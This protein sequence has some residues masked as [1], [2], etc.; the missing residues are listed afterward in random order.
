MPLR[1]V[2]R[3]LLY[4][5][6]FIH[7]DKIPSELSL[8]QADQ[9]Q[10]SQPLL[11]AYSISMKVTSCSVEVATRSPSSKFTLI[12][13]FQV[14]QFITY[15]L[16]VVFLCSAMLFQVQNTFKYYLLKFQCF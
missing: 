2:C 5:Q 7:I 15:V 14:F 10:L 4:Y 3:R 16:P 12:S 1:R 11:T 13:F 6:V 8:L 9:S